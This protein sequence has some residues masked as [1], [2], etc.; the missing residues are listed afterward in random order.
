M[1]TGAPLNVLD[2][3]ATGDGVTDDSDAI[4]A[5]LVAAENNS[6]YFPA[7]TYLC[8]DTL[9][10]YSNTKLIGAGYNSTTILAGALGGTKQLLVNEDTGG[11]QFVYPNS[12]IS[13]DGIYFDGDDQT[14]PAEYVSFQKTENVSVSNCRFRGSHYLGLGFAGCRNILVQNCVFTQIG[15]PVV[16]PEGGPALW[17]G[18]SRG[19]DNTPSS[20]ATVQNNIFQDLEWAAIY[21]MCKNLVID[22]NSITDVKEAGIF[23]NSTVLYVVIT[24]NNIDSVT[25]K[26][27]SGA[28]IEIGCSYGVISGNVISNTANSFI[29]LTDASVT[30]IVGNTMNQCGTDQTSFPLAA[31]ISCRSETALSNV[32]IADNNIINF[33]TPTASLVFAGGPGSALEKITVLNNTYSGNA[34]STGK[35]L[36]FDPAASQ[37]N[38]CFALNNT[39]TVDTRVAVWDS[40]IPSNASSQFLGTAFNQG[41]LCWNTAVT[42]GQPK[43]WVCTVAGTPGT[44]ASLGNL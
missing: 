42:S 37:G 4:N 15:N 27:I 26:Y 10:V 1:V 38:A 44:W 9:L 14:Y 25:K 35:T 34:F 31:P 8:D 5:A 16:T 3:G 41:S 39:G 33:S 6:L 43:G 29:A 19:G 11:A 23:I 20:I 22:G 40:L 21:G 36:A 32:L 28:G 7:G 13:L 24:N 2:Y 12:N 18:N 30:T 17:F